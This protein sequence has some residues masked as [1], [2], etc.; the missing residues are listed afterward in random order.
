MGNWDRFSPLLLSLLEWVAL[1][2]SH[3]VWWGLGLQHQSLLMPLVGIPDQASEALSMWRKT[4]PHPSATLS[5]EL[6]FSLLLYK[7]TLTG[8]SLGT[9]LTTERQ[10]RCKFSIAASWT[11]NHSSPSI[12]VLNFEPV[13]WFHSLGDFIR[14]K[15]IYIRS[16]YSVNGEVWDSRVSM[17]VLHLLAVWP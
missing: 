12:L 3:V 14:S 2:V 4:T 13:H 5:Q 16:Q 15:R 8:I 6:P 7:L 10:N 9:K 1:G 11:P 17:S